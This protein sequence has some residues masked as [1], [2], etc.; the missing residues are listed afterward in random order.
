MNDHILSECTILHFT[1]LE[2]F[3]DNCKN[4]LKDLWLPNKIGKFVISECQCLVKDG[5][6]IILF[7]K[8]WYVYKLWP[9]KASLTSQIPFHFLA[10]QSFQ[11]QLLPLTF[12]YSSTCS[13]IQMCDVCHLCEV[14]LYLYFFSVKLGSVVFYLIMCGIK[15]AYKHI[16]SG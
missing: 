4:F 16:E 15:M 7:A 9:Y 10:W 13:I 14:P 11:S 12:L 1:H 2:I 3:N 6:T 8:F 5:E